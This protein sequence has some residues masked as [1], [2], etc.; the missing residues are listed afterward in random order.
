MVRTFFFLL[1]LVNLLVLV[2]TQGYL[3]PLSNGREPGRLTNQLA[4]EKLRIVGTSESTGNAASTA[5]ACRLI[6][7]LVP[8]DI[9]R[10]VAQVKEKQPDLALAVKPNP[11]PKNVYWV[12]IPPLPNRSA[13][14]RK[15]AELK[16]RDIASASLVLEAGSDQYAISLGVYLTESAANDYLRELAK[17]DVRSAKLQARENP[18]DKVFLEMRGPVAPLLKQVAEL[19][20]GQVSAKVADCPAG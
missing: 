12:M 8:G 11:N 15:M 10:L 4:P 9:Q 3:G 19:L 20:E 16:K 7:G 1:L 5:E 17:R 18:L 14:D 13:A 2:W 6:S